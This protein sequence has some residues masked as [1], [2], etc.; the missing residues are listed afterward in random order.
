MGDRLK[1]AHLTTVDMSLALLLSTELQVDVE[2]G[3]D[4][5]GISAPGP[6]VAQIE[7]LGV[8]HVAIPSLSRSWDLRSDLRSAR[9]LWRVLR[10]ERPDVLHTHNPKTGVIGRVLGRVA[11]VPAV[12]NTCHGLWAGP[13]DPWRTRALVLAVEGLAAQLSH[14]ELYQ[15][16]DDERALHR[17]VRSSKATVVGNGVDLER[18]RFDEAGRGRLRREWGVSPEDV[19]VVGVGRRVREKGLHE[20]AEVAASLGD[21]ARFVWVGPDDGAKS[22][23]IDPA[24]VNSLELVGEQSDMPAVY[25]AADVFVLP[26]HREG[27]SR[28]GM[29]AAACGRPMIL[30]DIRGCRELG[31]D[32]EHLLLVP[33]RAP[34]DL[35]AAIHRLLDDADLRDRLGAAAARR[36]HAEFDQ[37]RVA[38]TSLDTYGRVLARRRGRR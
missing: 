21:R 16:A 10:D 14:A 38:Q 37:R 18:F 4:V 36:A 12:V 30:T 34:A 29:E 13:G 33:P 3:H 19:L 1:V 27:F 11:G 5:L 32:G 9:E 2:A 31:R 25:S 26:T 23:R 28:S 7:G 35:A 24:S 15:N 6:Y 20:L 17:V 8:R 22:D